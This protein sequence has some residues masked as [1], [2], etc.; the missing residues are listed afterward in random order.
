M[1]D[2]NLLNPQET[3]RAIT[4]ANKLNYNTMLRHFNSR[5]DEV[6]EEMSVS[7]KLEMNSQKREMLR[8]SL[9]ELVGVR[10]KE[11]TGSKGESRG[12]KTGKAERGKTSKGSLQE[13]RQQ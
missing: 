5:V 6:E 7:V 1:L 10:N 9:N 13:S 4:K 2:K 11:K 12:E 8:K 3:V